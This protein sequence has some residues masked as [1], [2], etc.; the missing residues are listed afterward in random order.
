MSR[1]SVGGTTDSLP[2]TVRGPSLFSGGS[3]NQPKVRR[4]SVVNTAAT[5][6]K[7]ALVRATAAGSGGTGLGEIPYDGVSAAI[8][9]AVNTQQTTSPTVGTSLGTITLGAAKG[10]GW[11]WTFED[12]GLVI[13]AGTGNGLIIICPSGTA[14]HIDF[15]FVWDE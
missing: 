8:A 5:E 2:T 11:V 15:E 14:Q 7:L 6:V 9:T 13:P 12:S 4:V 10:S 3:T 1:F